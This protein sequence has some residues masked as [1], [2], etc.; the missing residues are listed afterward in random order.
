VSKDLRELALPKFYADLDFEDRP[1][2][3]LERYWKTIMPKY[4]QFVKR[5]WVRISVT[6]NQEFTAISWEDAED[7]EEFEPRYRYFLAS[8]ILSNLTNLV[9][10]DIDLPRYDQPIR[11]YMDKFWETTAA[12]PYGALGKSIQEDI[13]ERGKHLTSLHITSDAMEGSIP[14]A[15]ICS[16]L[17]RLPNLWEI[18]LSGVS[19]QGS[20]DTPK[21]GDIVAGMQH[22]QCIEF[23]DVQAVDDAWADADW[24]SKLE[25]ISLEDCQIISEAGLE[26]LIQRHA[27]SLKGLNLVMTPPEPDFIMNTG[28]SL[29]LPNLR[30][31][32]VD[33]VDLGV[34]YVQRFAICP[35][36]T[37]IELG[38]LQS[39]EAKDLLQ[40]I[41]TNKSGDTAGFPALKELVLAAEWAET[42][43]ATME[44]LE[45]VCFENG[46]KLVINE[47]DSDDEY[48]S[49]EE[50][51]DDISE[52]DDEDGDEG[53]FNAWEDDEDSDESEELD[54]PDSDDNESVD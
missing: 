41:E 43:D 28:P 54:Q 29:E 25:V 19:E 31:L 15:T 23:D 5:F 38:E 33:N 51:L 16:L 45:L 14:A 1:N 17:A 21:L 42:S 35:Q 52:M 36:L 27:S 46:I 12:R 39:M 53:D 7:T 9:E 48:Y 24:Q 34:S 50:A 44:S 47:P 32:A 40:M 26:K 4:G 11:E 2:R 13:A 6:E 10:I 37:R 20:T 3:T 18:E 22:L 30:E 49:D 8:T